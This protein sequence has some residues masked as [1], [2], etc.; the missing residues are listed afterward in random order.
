MEYLDLVFT[1]YDI[2]DANYICVT[3]NADVAPDDEA[4]EVTDDFRKLMKSTLH[5]RRKMAVVR[6]EVAEKLSEDMQAFFCVKFQIT[7]D[8]IFRTKMPMKLS[9]IFAISGKLP[10]PL[11]KALIY[12]P[13]SP[14]PSASDPE[15]RPVIILS[16]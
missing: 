7:P 1:R 4:L 11:K 3:R 9:Y 12:P 14:Q 5:K 2:S 10:E 16:I 6:L 8:Q 15:E 13:F